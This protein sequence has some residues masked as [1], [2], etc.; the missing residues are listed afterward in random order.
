MFIVKN[1][2]VKYFHSD[3]EILRFY[4]EREKNKGIFDKNY[5]PKMKNIAVRLL[6]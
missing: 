1:N 2:K 3:K 4:E 6:Y 5:V